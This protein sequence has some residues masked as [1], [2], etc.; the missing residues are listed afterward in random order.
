MKNEELKTIQVL[1]NK[2]T[3]PTHTQHRCVFEKFV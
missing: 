3:I 2:Y 1:L